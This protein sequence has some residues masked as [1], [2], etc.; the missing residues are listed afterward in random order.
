MS[1]TDDNFSFSSIISFQQCVTYWV[2]NSMF[3]KRDALFKGITKHVDFSQLTS[4]DT[5][6]HCDM[7]VYAP[8][9][10]LKKLT[11]DA[12]SSYIHKS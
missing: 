10:L 9:P 1:S 7:I 6:A 3:D 11:A 12:V 5:K 2:R 4:D 8:V